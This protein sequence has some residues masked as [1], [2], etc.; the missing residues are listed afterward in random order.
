MLI[1]GVAALAWFLLHGPGRPWLEEAGLTSAGPPARHA[2]RP[3][4][5]T[6]A[7]DPGRVFG[8]IPVSEREL[9]VLDSGAYVVGYD[10]ARRNPAWVAY[11]V[12]GDEAFSDYERHRGFSTDERTAAQV[13]HEDFTHSGYARGHMAPSYVIFSRFGPEAMKK[14]YL[15]S[16]IC[17][18]DMRLNS[19]PWNRLESLVSGSRGSPSFAAWCRELWVVTGPVFDEKVERLPSRVEVPDGFYKILLDV[20]EETGGVRVLAFH[21]DNGPDVGPLESCLTS[22]DRVEALT[23]L[24]FFPALEDAVEDEVEARQPSA[25]WDEETV[26][27]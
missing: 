12:P 20:D 25:L 22:I 17:P 4:T 15:L 7:D 14:T 11:R 1:L 5:A 23:R 24:D 26:A 6:D 27:R 2:F 10:E 19:G 13:R 18:Q 21:M 16:N 8:G 3:D 9:L